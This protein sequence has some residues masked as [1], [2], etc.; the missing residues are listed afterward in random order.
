[1]GNIP[2]RSTMMQTVDVKQ[3][4]QRLS[5][6]IERTLGGDEIVLTEDGQPVVKLVA[7][8]KAT[9]HRQFGSA[10]GAFKIADDFD[11]PLEDY[12]EYM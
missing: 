12:Q 6:L 10:K 11:V 5:E 4:G 9:R 1:M 7:V 8:K 3:A 2:V